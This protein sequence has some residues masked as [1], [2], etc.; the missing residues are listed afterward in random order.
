MKSS[1]PTPPNNLHPEFIVQESLDKSIIVIHPK[2]SLPRGYSGPPATCDISR[3]DLA[4]I[5]KKKLEELTI[6]GEVKHAIDDENIQII[7][8]SHS[9]NSFSG[10]QSS[11]ENSTPV[12]S[13]ND[14]PSLLSP[15]TNSKLLR[16][17]HEVQEDLEGEE[18][19]IRDIEGYTTL[20][21]DPN[22]LHPI[23][24]PAFH[25]SP[26][27]SNVPTFQEVSERLAKLKRR[28]YSC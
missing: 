16:K 14:Y 5:L 9:P 26:A 23:P 6:Q 2:G 15:K 11:K 7:T 20:F 1:Q 10:S 27:G 4:E 24:I 25:F 12:L 19:G 8:L 18:E 28:T 22:Q 21:L 17:L 13:R 3:P